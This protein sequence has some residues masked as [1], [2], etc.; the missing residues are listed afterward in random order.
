M[1]FSGGRTN[2]TRMHAVK[3]AQHIWRDTNSHKTM[4]TCEGTT[5][6]VLALVAAAYAPKIHAMKHAQHIWHA[7]NSDSNMNTC[8]GTTLDVLALDAAAYARR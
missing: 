1:P 2:A 6:D 7:T 3:H 5:L 8:R 4:Y